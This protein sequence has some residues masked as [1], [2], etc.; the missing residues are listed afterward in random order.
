[1]RICT[2]INVN[3]TL[4]LGDS[5][6]TKIAQIAEGSQAGTNDIDI[7]GQIAISIVGIVVIFAA[8]IFVINRF[9]NTKLWFDRLLSKNLW[10]Q[11]AI[12]G[13]GLIVSFILSWYFLH[14]SGCKWEDFCESKNLSEWLLP[15][16]LL[17][18]SNALNNLYTHCVN[19]WALFVSSIIYVIGMFIFNGMIN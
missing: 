6:V 14:I 4:M 16:Y 1:M 3:D 12:L 19:G 2:A 5:I 13:I 15:L 9:I 18:D 8:S 17:I 11:F 7:G 10:K